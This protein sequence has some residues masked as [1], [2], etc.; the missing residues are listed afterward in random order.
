[1]YRFCKASFAWKPASAPPATTALQGDDVATSWQVIAGLQVGLVIETRSLPALTHVL[2]LI[3]TFRFSRPCHAPPSGSIRSVAAAT[4]TFYVADPSAPLKLSRYP[5]FF[6]ATLAALPSISEIPFLDSC[7]PGFLIQG[8][9]CGRHG[10]LYTDDRRMARPRLGWGL[11]RIVTA[12][13]YPLP[14]WNELKRAAGELMEK[15]VSPTIVDLAGL[16]PVQQRGV[17]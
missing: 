15:T 9:L 7:F 11:H 17:S 5:R 8:S 4:F 12:P 3:S 10:R 14:R 6:A 1:M 2:P 13:P 16:H